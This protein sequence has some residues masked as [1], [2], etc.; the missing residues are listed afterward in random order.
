MDYKNGVSGFSFYKNNFQLYGENFNDDFMEKLFSLSKFRGGQL[1]FSMHGTPKEYQGIFN[2][3]N[4][5]IKSYKVINNILAFVNT[6]PSL[7]TFSLPGYHKHGLKVKN[8]YMNFTS[9]ND[10]MNVSNVYLDSKELKILGKGKANFKKDR[11]NMKLNLKTDLASAVSKVP[12]VGHILF[13]D[14]SISTSLSIKGK[15]SDPK[16]KSLIAKDIIVAPLNIIK[17]TLLYPYHLLSQMKVVGA[18]EIDLS[19]EEDY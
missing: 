3:D 8:A 13:D 2:I 5:V 18:E 17:R 11:V 4:T 15:L 19:E 6:I 14:D 12:V 9:L 16:V 1:S 10:N 7:V